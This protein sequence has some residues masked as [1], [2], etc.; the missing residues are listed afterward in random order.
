MRLEKIYAQYEE[1]MEWLNS[2][3]FYNYEIKVML[4]RLSEITLK[5]SSHDVLSAVDHFSNQLTIQ[6]QQ[7]DTIKHNININN[8]AIN[9]EVKK[10]RTALD[11]RSMADHTDIRD[12]IVTFEMMFASLKKEF[13]IFLSRWM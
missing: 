13:N 3:Y 9:A 8:D 12:S 4:N 7:I 6:K 11:H 1:N 2:L 5:N 10:N